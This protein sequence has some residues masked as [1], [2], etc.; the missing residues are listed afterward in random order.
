MD[1]L[2]DAPFSLVFY[3]YREKVRKSQLNEGAENAHNW[4]QV[5]FFA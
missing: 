4:G 3:Y 2:G 1:S 5:L